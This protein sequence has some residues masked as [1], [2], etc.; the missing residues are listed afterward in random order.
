MN[1][2]GL[3]ALFL[4]ERRLAPRREVLLILTRF[5]GLSDQALE[6]VGFL[7]IHAKG[8][9]GLG[10]YTLQARVQIHVLGLDDRPGVLRLAA[11]IRQ[12]LQVLA[13]AFVD[14]PLLVR[15]VS[16][17]PS[18]V[19]CA[20]ILRRHI[21]CNVLFHA[22]NH[23]LSLRLAAGCLD[24]VKV[25]L[26]ACAHS[27]VVV[28]VGGET[29]PCVRAQTEGGHLAR[30]PQLRVEAQVLG[31][32]Q[33]ELVQRHGARDGHFVNTIILKQASEELAFVGVVRDVAT[34]RFDGWTTHLADLRVQ[35]NIFGLGQ[36][37]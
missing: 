32:Q 3:Q 28:R 20:S 5:V 24:L 9:D 10:A 35:Q 7:H 22:G 34:E 2:G 8:L 4:G 11:S 12:L 21:F 30:H 31:R 13:Q 37:L 29:L 18:P 15:D 1:V 36:L 25:F 33:L 17:K 27:A 26:Q 16:A 14:L 19:N 23:L 6:P